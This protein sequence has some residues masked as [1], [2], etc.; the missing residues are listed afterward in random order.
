MDIKEEFLR[1]QYEQIAL[2]QPEKGIYLVKEQQTGLLYLQKEVD[3]AQFAIYKKLEK[4]KGDGWAAIH[5]AVQAGG[6]YLIFE[7]L[8]QG[9]TLS[10]KIKDGNI[11]PKKK[12]ITYLCQLCDA[13]GVL[14]QNNMIHRDIQPDNVMITIDDKLKLIDFGSSR[15]YSSDKQG[16]TMLIG[17][18]GYAAPEQY[19]LWQTDPRTDIYSAGV[20]LHYML[21]GMTLQE[22]GKVK[23]ARLRKIIRKCTEIDAGKRYVQ[24]NEL[25]QD[26]MMTDFG[27]A[28]RH[29][30]LGIP[31]FRPHEKKYRL[32]IFLLGYPYLFL[33]IG[34]I[35]EGMTENITLP[36]PIF[37]VFYVGVLLFGAIIP[38]I[39]LADPFYLR[40]KLFRGR[41]YTS[42]KAFWV[43]CGLSY[44]SMIGMGVLLAIYY[45]I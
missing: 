3:D 2:L 8:I 41:N 16:D 23:N 31:G 28:F 44:L 6:H 34:G 20:L 18:V 5:E 39:L 29:F 7:E 45:N 11:L 26:L 25:K 27:Y 15:I 42:S 17:T 9:N 37:F 43:S 4:I 22:G 24:V 21:T 14:H 40:T 36:F 33:E 1:L 12:A 19:G 10:E 38:F 32:L 35:T 30:F 13:L